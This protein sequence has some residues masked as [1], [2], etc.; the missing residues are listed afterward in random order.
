MPKTITFRMYRCNDVAMYRSNGSLKKS[1]I[2]LYIT[3]VRYT[4]CMIKL[5]FI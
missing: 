3:T 5:A 2:K 4:M 1:I